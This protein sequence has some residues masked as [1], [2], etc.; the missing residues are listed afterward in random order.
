MDIKI[1]QSSGPM[2]NIA[3]KAVYKERGDSLVRA[4]TTAS[5]LEAE[6][7]S[8]NITKT[9]SKETL[10]EPSSSGTSS[11]SGTRRQETMGHTITQ[12]RFKNVSKLSNDPLL[13]RGNTL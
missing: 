11:G 1:P 9:R 12:T 3:D 13:A 8:G 10:N 2:E 4:A 7:D 6:Q 5:C